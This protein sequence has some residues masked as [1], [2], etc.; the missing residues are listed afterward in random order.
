MAGSA[1]WGV[2]LGITGVTV[3]NTLGNVAFTTT[4]ILAI[5]CALVAPVCYALAGIYIKLRAAHLPPPEGNA[6]FSQLLVAPIVG[7]AVPLAPPI[8][9]PTLV[10]VGALL[11]LALLSSAVAY[12][13]FYRLM[14]DIG[15]TR[16]TTITFVIPIFGMLWGSLFLGE[17]ITAGMLTGCGI[18]LA[19][20]WLVVA[21]DS[22]AA[23]RPLAAAQRS[24]DGRVTITPKRSNR[25]I[26]YRSSSRH[27]DIE[28]MP[29]PPG[30]PMVGGTI[31]AIVFRFMPPPCPIQ[32]AVPRHGLSPRPRTDGAGRHGGACGSGSRRN[33]DSTSFRDHLR[34]GPA[35]VSR[36]TA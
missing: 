35:H 22:R 15:P 36:A 27:S 5:L 20:T 6:A 16:V 7:L 21:P 12:L 33:R 31:H 19:G 25:A 23:V 18:M 13:M 26:R 14:A 34:L 32:P 2:G 10:Q 3:A 1:P 30:Q 9:L 17:I 4:T 11:A 28:I 8:A 24:S 29:V